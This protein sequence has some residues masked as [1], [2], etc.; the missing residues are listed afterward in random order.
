MATNKKASDTG[1]NLDG[2]TFGDFD[3]ESVDGGWNGP[4][5][6]PRLADYSES[7]RAKELAKLP[8]GSTCRETMQGKLTI[9]NAWG[10]KVYALTV[11]TKAG[12]AQ[13]LMPGHGMLYSRLHSVR[14]GALVRITYTGPAESAK[15]GRQPAA[16]YEIKVEKGG[17]LAEPRTDVTLQRREEAPPA[18]TEDEDAPF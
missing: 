16:T 13:V 1:V 15:P 7:R 9:P 3:G 8:P 6:N 10:R 4:R 5:W 14:E 17:K 2:E 18:A 12:V 11:E